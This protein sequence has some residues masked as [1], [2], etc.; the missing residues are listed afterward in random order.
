[1]LSRGSLWTSSVNRCVGY[2]RGYGLGIAAS[3]ANLYNRQSIMTA[4]EG[5]P[6]PALAIRASRRALK[7]KS[8]TDA[9]LAGFPNKNR[10]CIALG[11]R[12]RV[13]DC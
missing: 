2:S 7:Q 4:K 1:M 6:E 3:R 5:T 9:T 12:T 13:S 11:G 10:R 8:P